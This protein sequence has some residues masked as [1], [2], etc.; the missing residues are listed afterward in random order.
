LTAAMRPAPSAASGQSALS[1][2][3]ELIQGR[4]GFY[5]GQRGGTVEGS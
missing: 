4:Y 1:P 5:A 3:H 2:G